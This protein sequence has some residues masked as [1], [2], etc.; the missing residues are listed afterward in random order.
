MD[1]KLRVAM[2]SFHT[3]PLEQPGV[4]NAGGMNVYVAALAKALGAQGVKVEIFTR[5]LESAQTAH[6]KVGPNVRLWQIPTK[7][8]GALPI[9]DLVPELPAFVAGVNAVI[10]EH[11]VDVIH[12]HYWLSGLAGLALKQQWQ[13]PLVHS[14]HT[15]GHTK[16]SALAPGDFPESKQRISAETEIVEKSDAL[17]A[18][19]EHEASELVSRY[20]ASLEK[21]VVIPPGVDRKIFHPLVEPVETTTHPLVD[22]RYSARPPVAVAA[23]PAPSWPSVE[24]ASGFSARAASVPETTGHRKTHYRQILGL[25]QHLQTAKI[26]LFAGRIQKLKNPQLL[27]ETLPNLPN[28]TNVIMLGGASGDSLGADELRA[29]AKALGVGDRLTILPPVPAATL[30]NWYRAADL[31]A[32]PSYNETY[33]LVAAE[34]ICCGTPVVAAAVGGLA[35]I[36]EDGVTGVLVGSHDPEAWAAALGA[37]LADDDAR[38]TLAENC[39]RAANFLTWDEVATKTHRLYEV[40]LPKSP[41]TH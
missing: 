6:T 18:A 22:A 29:Q 32:V 34:A 35:T 3:N 11:P 33:G 41:L 19:T 5:A 38:E 20:Q 17:I 15:L 24:P 40:A 25:P 2:I 1:D 4:G 16:N 37:L 31:V 14:M 26:V 13:L 21:I 23:L 30:A 36:I 28:D 7:T 12:S 10:A 8:P 27:V 9:N 39:A